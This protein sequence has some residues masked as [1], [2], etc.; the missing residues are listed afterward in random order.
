MKTHNRRKKNQQHE[1]EN[2]FRL[3][4]MY[5]L[6]M[7]NNKHTHSE[8]ETVSQSVS[9][10]VSRSRMQLNLFTVGMCECAVVLVMG[11]TGMCV[12]YIVYVWQSCSIRLFFNSNK[13]DIDDNGRVKKKCTTF[14]TCL[15]IIY[16]NEKEEQKRWN[17]NS[18]EFFF[19]PLDILDFIYSML[20]VFALNS[21]TTHLNT[22]KSGIS[23]LL[24]LLLP[25][26]LLLLGWKFE[27]VSHT[28]FLSHFIK[29]CMT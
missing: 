20:S 16:W 26:L 8:R 25:L 2:F 14:A 10:L 13:N 5:R 7:H 19:L 22:Y 11:L 24:L 4:K 27:I 21:R 23:L 12:M 17:E 3:S 18:I 6:K 1:N 29:W 9:Q 15:K 28:K